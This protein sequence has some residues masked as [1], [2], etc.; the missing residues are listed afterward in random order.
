MDLL[1]MRYEV[2]V[3]RYRKLPSSDPSPLYLVTSQRVGTLDSAG[4][5]QP[6]TPQGISASGKM[7]A[8]TVTADW[9][10]TQM[11]SWPAIAKRGSASA[12]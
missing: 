5:R 11:R 1:L 6:T 3:H 8:D 4:A 7:G 9:P 2:P 12:V 10:R